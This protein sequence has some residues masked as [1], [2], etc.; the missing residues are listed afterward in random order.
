MQEEKKQDVERDE[1]RL[2]ETLT[3]YQPFISTNGVEI[4]IGALISARVY[5]KTNHF[6]NSAS[7]RVYCKTRLNK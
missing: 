2:M 6:L 5:E 1:M 4:V 7:I 3:I